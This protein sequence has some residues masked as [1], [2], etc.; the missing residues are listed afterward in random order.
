MIIIF[1]DDLGFEPFSDSMVVAPNIQALRGSGMFAAQHMVGHSICSPSRAAL[2]TGRLSIRTGIY[3]G[4]NPDHLP[5]GT[6]DH[7]VIHP[8]CYGCLPGNETTIAKMLGSVGYD[9]A[10]VSKWHLGYAGKENFTGPECLPTQRGFDHFYGTPVTHCEG[11]PNYPP[12]PIYRDLDRV[13]RLGIEVQPDQLT[14]LYTQYAVDFISNHSSPT[15][16]P[17]FLYYALDATHSAVYYP[18]RFQNA[19]PRGPFGDAVAGADWSV[20]QIVKAVKDSGKADNTL[21]I[22]TGDK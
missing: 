10:A 1:L 3:S 13:A 15:A 19:T 7:R 9:T 20:G 12:V 21:I 14:D 18:D 16:D 11:P 5:A 8:N 4:L 22:Y 6:G 17:Y 2:L